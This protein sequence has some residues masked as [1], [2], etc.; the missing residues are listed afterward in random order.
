MPSPHPVP[1]YVGDLTRLDPCERDMR[2]R[3]WRSET[4]SA[5]IGS[6]LHSFARRLKRL[7][8]VIPSYL[9]SSAGS[10]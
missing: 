10:S 9:H 7:L 4:I 2:L 6:L 3:R 5:W 1:D 8:S